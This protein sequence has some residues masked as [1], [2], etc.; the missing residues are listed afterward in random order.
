MEGAGRDN[1]LFVDASE[2]FGR[3]G[4]KTGALFQDPIAQVAGTIQARKAS[5]ISHVAG[6]EEIAKNDFNISAGRY[7]VGEEKRRVSN[8]L[9]GAKSVPLQDIAEIIRPQI[10]SS[11]GS[12]FPDSFSG[13]FPPGYRG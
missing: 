5:P 9:A 7:V 8:A 1:I 6:Y 13:G 2:D 12:P 10:V 4:R 11:D 3:K